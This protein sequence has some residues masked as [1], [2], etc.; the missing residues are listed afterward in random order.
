[1]ELHLEPIEPSYAGPMRGKVLEVVA[2]DD[3]RNVSGLTLYQVEVYR[4]SPPAHTQMLPLCSLLGDLGGGGSERQSSLAVG[5]F[6]VVIFLEGLPEY[7][8]ICGVWPSQETAI[9]PATAEVPGASWRRNGITAE[10]SASGDLT[11]S[12]KTD[13]SLVIK[14]ASGANLL[15]LAKVGLGYEVQLGASASLKELL[16]SDAVAAFNSHTHSETGATTSTPL[17]PWT[18]SLLTTQTKAS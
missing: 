9:A 4:L 13:R 10:M 11:L 15:R 14:D 17:V 7:P 8:V 5:Q 3:P 12:L 6:V 18:S 16:T 1:M 2:K